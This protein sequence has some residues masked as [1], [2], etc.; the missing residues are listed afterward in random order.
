MKGR[1]HRGFSAAQS[2]LLLT[3]ILTMRYSVQI[4]ALNYMR[5][6]N[7]CKRTPRT[8]S[9]WIEMVLHCQSRDLQARLSDKA[10]RRV[11]DG[12]TV[13]TE[14]TPRLP[15]CAPFPRGH[16]SVVS[17]CGSIHCI[18]T[19]PCA[20]PLLARGGG[21]Y[22]GIVT[23]GPEWLNRAVNFCSGADSL[24]WLPTASSLKASSWGPSV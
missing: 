18:D 20:A 4:R 6:L 5:C 11:A 24:A 12:L 8:I 1:Y 22:R 19:G 17:G 13:G 9:Y 21:C 3:N 15:H 7:R 23:Q 2:H 10:A 16:S 14:D